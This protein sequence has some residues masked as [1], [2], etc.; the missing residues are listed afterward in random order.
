[1]TEK[2]LS[3]KASQSL[4]TKSRIL[5]AA[6]KLFNESGSDAVTT[7]DI[8]EQAQ[9]SPGNLYYHFKNKNAIIRALFYEIEIFSVMKWREKSPAHREVRFAD[10]MSF[11]FG[12]L[13]KHKFFFRELAS[14]LK[15][16][17]ILAREW[18]GVYERLFSVMKE[19]LQGWVKQGLIKPFRQPEEE[20]IFIETI[21]ILAGFSQVHHEA[22]HGFKKNVSEE[23]QRLLARFL[24]P[25][26]TEK[27]QRAIEL[28][29]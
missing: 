6:L 15:N 1:M 27:G 13:A 10:F 26:H 7:H 14:I 28:Y 9:L 16:D 2:E 24:Y 19:S 23:S 21:W 18:R 8:A 3:A 20:D 22:R 11:Y 4:E 12:G 25:Y 17:P 5:K 29:L